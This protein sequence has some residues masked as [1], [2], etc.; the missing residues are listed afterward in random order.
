MMMA[1]AAMKHS[2][3]SLTGRAYRVLRAAILRGE[4]EDGK[5]LTE[6]IANEKIKVGHT[7]FRE[8]C[9]Q[10]LNEGFLELMPRR[11]YFLPQMTMR[12]VRDV[13]EARSLVEGQAAELAVSRATKDQIGRMAAVL[14]QHLPSKLNADTLERIIEA[15]YAFHRCLAE[16]TQNDELANMARRLLDRSARLVYLLKAD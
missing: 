6:A 14:K 3:G 11:G 7:P 12:K 5:F 2:D 8:A 13:L 15:K 16:M 9:N 1:Q 10:L 4:L